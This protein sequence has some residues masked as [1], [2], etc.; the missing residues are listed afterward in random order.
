M[1]KL[2]LQLNTGAFVFLKLI[3]EFDDIVIAVVSNVPV[4]NK[5]SVPLW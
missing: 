1:S 3:L 5:V 2:N 4:D